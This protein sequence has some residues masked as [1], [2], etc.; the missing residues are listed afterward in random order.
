MIQILNIE[1]NYPQ[2]LCFLKAAT[3]TSQAVVTLKQAN[4]DCPD[5]TNLIALILPE[6]GK[7]M[8]LFNASNSGMSLTVVS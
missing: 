4:N 5:F 8:I 3:R 7:G 6:F 2:M 1:K